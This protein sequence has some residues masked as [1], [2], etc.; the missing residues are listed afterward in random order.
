MTWWQKAWWIRVDNGP[1]LPTARGRR[2]T[3]RAATRAVQETHVA[4]RTEEVQT[5]VNSSLSREDLLNVRAAMLQSGNRQQQQQQRKQV[6]QDLQRQQQLH[7]L[8]DFIGCVHS[9]LAHTD[10]A[11]MLDPETLHDIYH[12]NVNIEHQSHRSFPH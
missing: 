1:H 3:W 5:S 8:H 7:L 2:R 4:E 6:Q 11:M 9:V 12:P 10:N